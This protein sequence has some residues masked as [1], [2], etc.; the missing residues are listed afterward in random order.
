M[1][2]TLRWPRCIVGCRPARRAH[3]PISLGANLTGAGI[4]A[5][6]F[7]LLASVSKVI[8]FCSSDA[9]ER[10]ITLTLE[11]GLASVPLWGDIK[12]IEH[13]VGQLLL[14]AIKYSW[15]GST[16]VI[17]VKKDG[18]FVLLTVA[19][20]GISL[21]KSE[22][23]YKIWDF[24]FRGK[25]AKERHVNGSGIGLYTVKKIVAAHHGSVQTSSTGAL[26][27]FYVRFPEKGYLQSQLG[28]L[29]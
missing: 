19:N 17:E 4:Q 24:G 1:S 6:D 28:L 21:P 5:Y 8:G 3:R 12:G 27:A 14:N 2:R 23:L 18:K 25:A 26:T 11:C 29:L 10:H 22:D 13:C 20:S 16:V 7:D 9:N 15:G